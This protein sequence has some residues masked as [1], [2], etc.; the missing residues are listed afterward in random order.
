MQTYDRER[1][2]AAIDQ[3]PDQGQGGTTLNAGLSPLRKVIAGLSGETAIII[4]TDGKTTRAR[5]VK[6]PLQI[7][8]E[9]ARD[10]DVCFYLINSGTPDME[11]QLVDVVDQIN[12]CSRVIP[13]TQYMDNPLYLSGALFTVKTTAYTRIKPVTQVVGFV[14]ND[15]LFDFD[16]SVILGAYNDKLDQLGNYLQGNP[17]AYVVAAGYTDSVGPDDYNK[18]LSQRRAQAVVDM[19]VDEY[20]IAPQRLEAVGYGEENPVADNS[21]AEGRAENRRVMATLEVEYEE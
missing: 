4:F 11:K 1:F 19:L 14:A 3:L 7:A 10:H 15:M 20:G 12:A 17:N 21:T 18:E 2:G 13:L 6:R 9:I 16:S 8:Q 5:N